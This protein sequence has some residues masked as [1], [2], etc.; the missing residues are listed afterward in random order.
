M[1]PAE[2]QRRVHGGGLDVD[3][4]EKRVRIRLF[5]CCSASSSAGS[6][7]S[8]SWSIITSATAW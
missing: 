7:T 1:T 3:D 5:R 2:R 4:L 6:V 8:A